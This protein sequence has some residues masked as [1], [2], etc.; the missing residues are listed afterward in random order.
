[1]GIYGRTIGTVDDALR[2]RCTL[3]PFRGVMARRIYTAI[4]RGGDLYMCGPL[5]SLRRLPIRRCCRL[6]G[7]LRPGGLCF[8]DT[9]RAC[10]PRRTAANLRIIPRTIVS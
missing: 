5:G 9:T 8:V 6:P 2:C 1:M 3:G 7:I 10:F 4:H